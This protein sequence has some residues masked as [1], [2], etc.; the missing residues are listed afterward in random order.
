MKSVVSLA[1]I[2]LLQS[3]A[4]GLQMI[5]STKDPQCIQ[6]TPKRIGANIAIN[7]SVSGVNED[8]ILFTVG[9]MIV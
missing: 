5:L 2:A 8:Q 4:N 1:L 7:Y 9:R 3:S 6:I